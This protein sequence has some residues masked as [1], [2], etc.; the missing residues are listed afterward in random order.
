MK[1]TNKQ[2]DRLERI[3]RKMA[4]WEEKR[5][6]RDETERAEGISPIRTV[7][8]AENR[9]VEEMYRAAMRS[10]YEADQFERAELLVADMRDDGRGECVLV[11]PDGKICRAKVKMG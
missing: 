3:R 7:G 10:Q 6:Q 2:E 1:V 11:R 8:E 4:K 5:R 9:R